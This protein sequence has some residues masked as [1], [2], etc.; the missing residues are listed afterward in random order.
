MT[1]REFVEAYKAK[2]F[3]NTKTGVENRVEFLKSTLEVKEY[4]PF[5]D[6]RSLA[7]ATIAACANFNDGVFV[8]DSLKKYMLFTMTMLFTYTSLEHDEDV[9]VDEEY[10]L[11]CSVCVDDGTLL[12][13]AIGLFAV[14]YSRCNDILNMMTAD[15][16]AE[17]NIERQIGRFLSGLSD[18][19][20]K[21]GDKLIN[22][23]E[24]LDIGQLDIDKL[25]K[26][27]DK[28]K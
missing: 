15:V 17:N 26:V 13:A 9:D 18:N 1:I 19:I 12:D 10:D 4:V 23:A 16:L 5:V 22:I 28:F 21:F 25:T 8:I 6:K 7:E 14:E 24:S 20:D 3:M 11:L 27:L 2:K